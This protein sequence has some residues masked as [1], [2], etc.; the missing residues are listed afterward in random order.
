MLEKKIRKYKLMDTHRELVRQGKLLE[1]RLLLKFLRN[2]SA[3]E[4]I[5]YI[6]NRT[7]K[8]GKNLIIEEHG[9]QKKKKEKKKQ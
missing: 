7:P 8:T 9:N 1:A 5:E 3:D 2:C 4:L 6:P